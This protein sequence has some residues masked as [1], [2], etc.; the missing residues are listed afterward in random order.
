M[1]RT[2]ILVFSIAP[3]FAQAPSDW[4]VM[5]EIGCQAAVPPSWTVDAKAP[6]NAQAPGGQSTVRLRSHNSLPMTPLDSAKLRDLK[7]DKMI[8][9]TPK[10]VFYSV[11]PVVFDKG[12]PAV[13][14]YTVEVSRT[15]G[16]CFL[17]IAAAPGQPDNEV[18]KIALTLTQAAK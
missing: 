1:F 17:Y 10:R 14:V 9:N 5:K 3:V 6:R 7:V 4:K 12:K 2:L 16:T 13:T 18:K 11:K 15:G 8:E